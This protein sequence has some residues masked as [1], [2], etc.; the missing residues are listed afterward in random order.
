MKTY[1]YFHPGGARALRRSGWALRGNGVGD[2]VAL[3]RGRLAFSGH[4]R[5]VYIT[6]FM[7]HFWCLK[8]F[9]KEMVVSLNDQS[10]N[11]EH[12]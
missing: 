6:I 12:D 11:F 10:S 1:D 7:R 5:D 2:T 9:F 8:Y 3:A 4:E